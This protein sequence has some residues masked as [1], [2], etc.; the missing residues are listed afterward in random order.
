MLSPAKSSTMN[1]AINDIGIPAE[2]QNARRR[3]RKRE[4]IKKTKII[5]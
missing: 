2:T 5:P 3:L 1:A 4:R